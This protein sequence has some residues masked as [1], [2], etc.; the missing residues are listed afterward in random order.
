MNQAFSAKRHASRKS[1]SPFL[2]QPSRVSGAHVA[3][4]TQIGERHGLAA[5]RVI[6]DG[7]EHDGDVLGTGSLDKALECGDV[8]VALEWG[9]FSW[10]SSRSQID[11]FRARELDV[12][13]CRV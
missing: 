4:G 3:Y 7:H 5:H 9:T 6:G 10:I 13:P 12:C 8:H 2:G 11:R 1:G